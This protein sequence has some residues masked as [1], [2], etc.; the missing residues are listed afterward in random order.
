MRHFFA[1]SILWL[2]PSGNCVCTSI[3]C[4]F[5]RKFNFARL[6]AQVRKFAFANSR[7]CNSREAFSFK[8]AV[9]GED[10]T[11]EEL[12][13]AAARIMTLQRANTVRGMKDAN[14]KIGCNDCRTIHDTMTQWPFT[15]NPD[16]QPF[17]EGTTKMEKKDFQKA[18]TMVYEKFGW[19]SEKGCPTADCLDYYEMDDVKAELKSLNLLP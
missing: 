1:C 16:K 10:I 9:T 2:F 17:S 13:K 8:S 14:G 5:R 6:S 12:Y 3:L 7:P 15:Q 19:D 11:T 4:N 18:L